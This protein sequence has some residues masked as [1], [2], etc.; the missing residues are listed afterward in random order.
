MLPDADARLRA[1]TDLDHNLVVDAGAGTGKTTVLIERIVQLIASGRAELH[2]IAAIT[3]TEKAA[4]ELKLRLRNVL[5]ERVQAGDDADERLRAALEQLDRASVSTIHAFCAAVLRERPA[6]AGVD[7]NFA[8]LDQ[9]GA[10]VLRHQVWERWLA[11]EMTT[12][13]AVLVRAMEAGISFDAMRDAAMYLVENRDLLS[14]I[15]GPVA[16]DPDAFVDV[17]RRHVDTLR[18]LQRDCLDAADAGCRQIDDL[19]VACDRLVAADADA[20]VALLEQLQ[21]RPTAGNQTNWKPRSRLTEVKKVFR[22]LRDALDAIRSAWSH[23]LCV[24]LTAWLT[25][26]LDTYDQVKRQR[27]A[28]DFA[29]LLIRT[30]ELLV[31][32]GS[33]RAQL[34]RRFDALLVDE[35]QDTDPLQLEIV[36]FL[37]ERQP[38][39]THWQEVELAPGKLFLVGDPK[40][41]IYRFRRADIELYEAATQ[42][43]ARAGA[44]LDLQTN[45]RSRRSLVAWFNHRF[46]PLIQ[47]PADGAYQPDYVDLA[48]PPDLPEEDVPSVRA[49][50][51]AISPDASSRS[52]ALR[53][54]ARVVA[55]YIA[56]MLETAQLPGADGVWRPLHFHDIGILFRDNEPMQAYEDAL[57]DH[58]LPFRVAGGSRFYG[59]EEVVAL[60]AL[61]R[62]VANPRDQVNLV[63]ALRGPFFGFSDEQLYRFASA[64]GALDYSRPI[65]ARVAHADGHVEFAAAFQSLQALHRRTMADTPA[66]LLASLLDESHVA[67]FCFLKPQGDQRVA[68]LL[69]LVDIARALE[70][71]GVRTLRGLSRFLADLERLQAEEGESPVAEESDDVIRLLTIHKAKGLEFPVVILADGSRDRSGRSPIAIVDRGA[72]R[73]ALSFG[74]VRTQNWDALKEWEKPRSD[75]EAIRLLYV[76]A[77]RARDALVIPSYPGEARGSFLGAL[78]GDAAAV[79]LV[80]PPVSDAVHRSTGPFRTDALAHPTPADTN[81]TRVWEQGRAALIATASGAPR[82]RS[83]TAIGHRTSPAV[84]PPL[85]IGRR[86]DGAQLGTLVHAVLQRI[87]LEEVGAAES[88]VAG[89]AAGA[90]MSTGTVRDACDLVRRAVSLPI[91]TRARSAGGFQREVPFTW[92]VPDG[93]V[94]GI[95]DLVFEERERLVIVDYK[96][97]DVGSGRGLAD[98][99]ALY[100]PQAVL[101]AAALE[102]ITGWPVKEVVFAFLRPGLERS[103]RAEWRTEAEKLLRSGFATSAQF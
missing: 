36:F 56:A 65:P 43:V 42:A 40:Q 55:E 101:Y 3:F 74:G 48:P 35:F 1:T 80:E 28:L 91:F 22:D 17:L 15:P 83:A 51:I 8:M 97:D 67:A 7:P 46:K 77:T 63:A 31:R 21:I 92:S 61:L 26:Y 25:G 32:Q 18:D 88:L 71:E 59:R 103:I 29:D 6:E 14:W 37:A 50:P 12:G 95:V 81:A 49:L 66:Q 57:R 99:V 84:Q 2:R 69:K 93:V 82:V 45:F 78:L 54:E 100:R 23:N 102:G 96:T 19:V 33:V 72:S 64:G 70:A 52:D 90:G 94:E 86:G 44:T 9:L 87:N 47:R 89:L 58:E 79:P 73:L 68:N 85:P 24:E 41:S 62:A 10:F 60:V 5:E 75:A 16:A 34:Q 76:A 98:R 39:A 53:A 4:G 20:A 11:S 38:R 30:R 13:P 27:G